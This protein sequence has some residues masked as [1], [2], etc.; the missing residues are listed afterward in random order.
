MLKTG[1][2]VVKHPGIFTTGM[3]MVVCEHN[4]LVYIEHFV[5]LIHYLRAQ[6]VI[7]VKHGCVMEENV[8][9]HMPVLAHFKMQ[10]V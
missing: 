9:N 1:D 2:C 6:F 10:Y 3:N 4:I 7:F 5:L 8:F